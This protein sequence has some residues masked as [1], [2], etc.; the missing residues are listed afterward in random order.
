MS[1]AEESGVSEPPAP[2]QAQPP[3]E[4]PT[5]KP[6]SSKPS[7]K[8]EAQSAGRGVL[9]I[10]AAKL[11]FMVIGAV[12]EFRLPAIVSNVTFGAYGVVSSLVSPINNVLIVGTIQ[13]V[14][15]FT[16]QD[17]EKARAVQRAGLHLMV[18][19]PIAVAFAATA[20]LF[21]T[22]F[23]DD[24]KT[25]PLM[26][27]SAI[28][29]GYSFYA[30]FVGRANGTRAFH[31]QA[32]LDMSFAT[33]RAAGI[34]GLAGAGFGLYGIISGWILA[35]IGIVL[36]SS[37]AI[38]LPGRRKD[39][40]PVQPM[41]PLLAFFGSVA[42][43]L[44]LM[45]F[46]MVID[47]LLLKRMATE[48]FQAH[49]EET[50]GF[51]SETLPLWMAQAAG[52]LDPSDA[53][54]AQVGYYRAVQNLARLSYQAIIAATFVIFPLVS[55]STFVSDKDA[56]RRYVRT[57]LRYSAIFAAAIGVV[58]AANPQALL[59][60]P[61]AA[62]YAFAGAPAL[63]LLALGNVAFAIFVIAGTILN[64]SGDTRRALI[65][66]ALTLLVAA[67]ANAIVIPRFEPGRELLTAC[68]AATSGAM[69]FGAALSMW[70]LKRSTGASLPLATA[71]R[72]LISGAGAIA[73]GRFWPTGG[74]LGTMLESCV[75]GLVFLV[76]LLVTRE[77]GRK[78]LAAVL[79]VAKRGS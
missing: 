73:M 68:A 20:P 23:H 72:V 78:D 49:A 17:P 79:A 18:G 34:L 53:A 26:M 28:L 38:G 64:G 36:I 6:S 51:V 37:F 41:R 47:Q 1:D 35:V 55:R 13:A 5:S 58:F 19:L 57:T 67:V 70:L 62:D 27:A 33:M 14:S 65:S 8:T 10:A 76:L 29:A 59:D 22:F 66:V 4:P 11:Y 3:S 45:N 43:Y 50:K 74:A 71:C 54:D 56:T 21:A 9:F 15:R 32:G 16:A 7:S 40:E 39:A 69:L 12:I 44:V 63:A 25:G 48:W 30:V 75:I 42:L 52:P 46:I 61:Y 2:S 31:K 24:R 60:I 77:F